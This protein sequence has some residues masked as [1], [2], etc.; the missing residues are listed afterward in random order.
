MQVV[1]YTKYYNNGFNYLITR[2]YTRFV[3]VYT[4]LA[5]KLKHMELL[6]IGIYLFDNCRR[7][8]IIVDIGIPNSIR[9]SNCLL[10]DLIDHWL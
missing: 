2:H 3:Q 9:V 6:L 10:S 4:A 8:T 7:H 1:S 5:L